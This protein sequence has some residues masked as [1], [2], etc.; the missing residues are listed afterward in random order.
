MIDSS[1][2]LTNRSSGTTVLSRKSVTDIGIIR[3]DVIKVDK[4]LKDRLVLSKVREG[5]ERQNQERLRRVGREETLEKDDD[6]DD[7]IDLKKKDPKPKR[8]GGLIAFLIGGVVS[9]I[10]FFALKFLPTILKILGF[11]KK[12]AKPLTLVVGGAFLALRQF[13]SVFNDKTNQLQGIDKDEIKVSR[14]ERT[15]GDFNGAL[16]ALVTSLIIG[17]AISMG[18]KALKGRN[19]KDAVKS[20]KKE[21]TPSNI[22]KSDESPAPKRRGRPRN[23]IEVIREGINKKSETMTFFRPA[24]SGQPVPFKRRRPRKEKVSIEKIINSESF[25]K[26]AEKLRGPQDFAKRTGQVQVPMNQ[27]KFIG[28]DVFLDIGKGKVK[29]DV[30]T[31]GGKDSYFLDARVSSFVQGKRMDKVKNE[32]LDKVLFDDRFE[33]DEVTDEFKFNDPKIKPKKRFSQKEIDFKSI[34]AAGRQSYPPGFQY[35]IIRPSIFE[36]GRSALSQ[37]GDFL[38]PS[39]LKGLLKTRG[40]IVKVLSNIGG[41]AFV[42]T[43]KQG[44]KGSI[45]VIPIL[46]DVFGFLL[47]YFVFGEPIG[48]AAFKA[49]G[50]FALSSLIGAVGLAVGGPVGAFAGGMLG[51]IGGDILGGIAYDLFF[52]TEGGVSA[53]SSATK[54]ALKGAATQTFEDGGYVNPDL[55][56]SNFKPLVNSVDKST[57][58][59]STPFYNKT[60]A[61]RVSFVPFPLVIPSKEQSQQ[62]EQL[63]AMGNKASETRTFSNLYKR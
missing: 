39:N 52:G 28:D 24:G 18:L 56:R 21:A 22:K 15:I 55:P 16:D 33:L 12:I 32:I 40:G 57:E 53:K 13:I 43:F 35:D 62:E 27:V 14:I 49:I 4:L 19:A 36:Q 54:G 1:K 48:R 44:L 10:G 50:S 5:I 17:G 3:E 6:R 46:G 63:I 58:I 8:G 7:D 29:L 51:G 31:F 30:I 60:T 25:Q 2:L 47:D 59:S 34:G 61:G 23:S 41:D 42:Q 20:L 38:S 26:K 9:T 45:G 11:I 37:A